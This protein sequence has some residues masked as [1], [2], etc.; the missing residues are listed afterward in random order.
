MKWFWLFCAIVT[1]AIAPMIE[2]L[3]IAIAAMLY[4]IVQNLELKNNK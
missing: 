3:L 2:V 4:H 1:V